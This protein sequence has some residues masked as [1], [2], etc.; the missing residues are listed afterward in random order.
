VSGEDGFS[1]AGFDTFFSSRLYYGTLTNSL[2]VTV[3]VTLLALAVAF[4]L[5][6]FMT[7]FRVA[8][9]RTA[10]IL[11][12]ASMMSPPFIGAYSWI[13]L[14]GNN[15]TITRLIQDLIG[16]KPPSI[17]GFAGIVL[18]LTLQLVPLI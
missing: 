12:L 10:Q 5:A 15:G 18:V 13:L 14:L 1:L 16:V 9:N 7:M 11:I 4:P 8:G 2:L 3:C 17:Y 6:Y